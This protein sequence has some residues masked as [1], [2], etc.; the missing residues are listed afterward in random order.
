MPWATIDDVREITGQGAEVTEVAVASSVI[1]IYAN[2]TTAASA[3]L[4]SRDLHW[5]KS[6]TAWQTVWQREQP[7]FESRSVTSNYT[8]DG[9]TVTH[10]AEW[11]VALAPMAARALKNLSWKAS[12]TLRTPHVRTP[13]GLGDSLDFTNER[14]DWANSS[15]TP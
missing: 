13:V 8:Q 9:I 7:G 2:R 4:R 12:R 3:G 14:S 10:D 6:A 15:W 5:L 1:D 11:N